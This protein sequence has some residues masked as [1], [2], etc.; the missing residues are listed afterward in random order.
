KII[1]DEIMKYILE[2]EEFSPPDKTSTFVHVDSF[3]ESSI[4]FFI[5][6]FTKTTNWGKWLAIKEE[7]AMAIKEII[8]QKAKA[9][10]A[11]PSQSIY[12]EN[13][14]ENELGRPV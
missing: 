1:R 13:W 3:N 8:E 7:F 11:F 12:L 6:C 9:D 10:F 5:Y 4:D 14:H 2:N